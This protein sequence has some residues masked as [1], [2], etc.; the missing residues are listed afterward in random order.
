[1]REKKKNR[2]NQHIGDIARQLDISAR[3]MRYYEELGLIVPNRSNGGFREYSRS[4]VEKLSTIIRLK[5]LGLKLEEIQDLIKIKRNTAHKKSKARL[6]EQLQKRLRE[7]NGKIKE[8]KDGI[9]EIETVLAIMEDCSS[10]D[11]AAIVKCEEC[12]KEQNK[13]MPGLMKAMF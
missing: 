6:A 4:E 11:D 2:Q 8:Y 1:M 5:K 12:L 10:C 7:F 9:K 3:S 13:K